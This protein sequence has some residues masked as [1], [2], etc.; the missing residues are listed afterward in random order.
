L[1]QSIDSGH[2]TEIEAAEDG[3]VYVMCHLMQGFPRA[4]L[5]KKALLATKG[6]DPSDDEGVVLPSD[7]G[8]DKLTSDG[9][10]DSAKLPSD[11]DSGSEKLP[12]D[13]DSSSLS[14]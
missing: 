5:P 13:E 10:S 3:H 9:G 2:A 11:A 12:S 4:K 7:D 8:S 14:I 6:R 1:V